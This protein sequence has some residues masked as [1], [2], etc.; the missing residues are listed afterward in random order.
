[1]GDDAWTKK[2]ATLSDTCISLAVG[3]GS[4]GD[5]A[6]EQVLRNHHGTLKIHGL[7]LCNAFVSPSDRLSRLRAV[8]ACGSGG[9]GENNLAF[10]CTRRRFVIE[11]LHLDVEGGVG[12][13]RTTHGESSPTLGNKGA[14]WTIEHDLD[15]VKKEGDGFDTS[16]LKTTLSKEGKRKKGVAFHVDRPELYEY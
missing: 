4:S 7:Q 13:R 2:L 11:T 3:I 16:V 9:S 14:S 8:S 12:E 10:K 1:M 15:D 5:P 6:L